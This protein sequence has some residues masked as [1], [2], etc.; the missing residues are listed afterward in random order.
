MDAFFARLIER[1]ATIDE[2]LSDDFESLPSLK[3]DDELAAQRLA[4]W[5]RS[6]ANGDWSLFGRRLHRDKLTNDQVLTRFATGRRKSSIS[7][8]AWID[9]AIWIETAL[10]SPSSA[11]PTAA[12]DP[13]EPCA[14]EHLFTPVID[15][16]ELL[17]WADITRVS[18]NFADSGRASLRR[19]LLKELTDLCAPAIY[20]RFAQ[21]RVNSAMPPDSAKQCRGGGTSRYDQFVAEMK[22]SGFRRLFEDKPVL[23]RLIASITRQWIDVSREFVLRLDSDLAALRRDFLLTSTHG[24]VVDVQGDLSDPHNGGRS[25]RIVIFDDGSRVVYKPKDLRLDVA[26][27]DLVDRLNRSEPPLELK[28]VRAISRPDY[29]WTEF[30]EHG[31]CAGQDGCNLFFRR[32]G[33]WLALFH[34]FAATDM[35]QENLIAAG[36]H[37]V[38]IDLETILQ[39]TSEANRVHEFEGEASAAAMEIIANSVMVVG[40][41][42]AYGRS[43]DNTVFA[44]GGMTSDWNAK[45]KLTWSNI[46]SDEMRPAKSKQVSN[47]NPNLPHV[48]GRYAKF[49]DHIDDFIAG[50][51]DYANFL[52]HRSRDA[53]QGGLFDGFAGVPVRRVIRPT[54]FYSMLLQRLKNH[55]TMEDGVTWSAQSDFIARLANWEIEV[56]PGWPLQRAE[57]SALLALN[58]PHFVSPSD[59]NEMRDASGF[60]METVADSGMDRARARVRSLDERE[61]AWQIEIIRANTNSASRPAGSASIGPAKPA[62]PPRADGTGVVAKE[63]FIAES[64]KIAGELSERAI[65]RGPGAAWIG[66][67]WL[68][69]AEVFQLVCLGSDLYNGASGIAVFLAAHAA[70]TECGPSGELALAALSDL[71]KKLR[72]RNA[73]RMARTLGIGGATGMGSIVY[74]LTVISKLLP[75]IDLFTDVQI[76]AELITDDLIAADKRLDVIGGSAGAILGLLRLYRDTQSAAVLGRA[77]KCGEHLIGQHR[78]G[79]DGRRNWLGQGLGAQALNGMSHGAAGFAYAFSSLAAATQREEFAQ[80]ASDCIA[81]ENS[82]YDAERHNWPDRRGEGELGWPCQW[83]HGAPG[84]GLARVAMIRR[85]ATDADL[86]RTDIRNALAGVEESWPGQVDTLCCGTLG[87]IEFMCEAGSALDRSDVRELAKRRL[88]AVLQNAVSSGDYRWNTGKRQFNLGFFR[89]IAGV[90]YTALRQVDGSL[91]NVLIWE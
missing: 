89:G 13:A 69:D 26:W 5:C 25:V 2:L 63:L 42:P 82:S 27:Y 60:C 86:L 90:G 4:A 84:I 83:C 57:R 14:F 74:A 54:R 52:L 28:A 48:D 77:A 18:G 65:R 40:L 29:G 3:G 55:R 50:F 32:A 61:I 76:A 68:G 22:R 23:L 19:L 16:A 91:P 15:K 7:P 66:L 44:M 43:P 45:I 38:P 71:R 53:N 58:V 41:L 72:S 59:G 30:V 36:D 46:N 12:R 67:D 17:L 21:E 33:A 10:Q 39:A 49:G 70:V 35:H 73:A 80:A 56:D 34:C 20:E 11:R 24:R 87:S 78:I 62:M 85:G 9:D 37:P 51:R 6:C 88:M 47:T 75:G 8:P 1:V 31:G 79:P 81:F 64:N